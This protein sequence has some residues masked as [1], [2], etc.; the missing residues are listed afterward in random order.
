VGGAQ[1]CR[2]EWG[3]GGGGECSR[4]KDLES[5]GT[6]TPQGEPPMTEKTPVAS[7][8]SDGM[9][10]TVAGESKDGK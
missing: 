5:G 7:P 6:T 3:G 2:R 4:G 8:G 10:F 9:N 1:E